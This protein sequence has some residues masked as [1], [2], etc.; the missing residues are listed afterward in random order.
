[1]VL[2]F[3][4]EKEY[5]CLGQWTENRLIGQE[6]DGK[7]IKLTYLYV[8]RLDRSN[9]DGEPEYECYVVTAIPNQPGQDPRAMTLLL[10]EAG[11]GTHCS[12]LADPYVDGMKLVGTR[13]DSAGK[14]GKIR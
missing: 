7:R 5:K 12:R 4:T 3:R 13:I 11:R 10:T 6:N 2:F 8:E 1:M 9:I 14:I